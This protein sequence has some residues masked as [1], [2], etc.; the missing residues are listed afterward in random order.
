[1]AFRFLLLSALTMA[2]AKNM[3]QWVHIPEQRI[4]DVI[5]DSYYDRQLSSDDNNMIFNSSKQT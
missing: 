3:L 2:A 5:I 4:F 1:M